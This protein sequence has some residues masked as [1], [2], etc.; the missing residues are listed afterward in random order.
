MLHRDPVTLDEALLVLNDHLGHEVEVTVTVALGDSAAEIM[1]AGG[2][3][4]R[5]H[6]DRD[7]ED[8][9]DRQDIVGLYDV[10]E[11]ASFD[12]TDPG[13][14]LHRGRTHPGVRVR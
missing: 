7:P 9:F 8:A 5:W 13:P 10:G 11:A 12:V 3:L 4:R 2:R 14:R 1:R 6:E